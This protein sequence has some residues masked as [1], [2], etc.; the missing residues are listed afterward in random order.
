[1]NSTRQFHVAKRRLDHTLIFDVERALRGNRSG[2]GGLP[3]E[4]P[5]E[6]DTD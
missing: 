3:F 6:G 4:Y 1:M 2:S 5:F